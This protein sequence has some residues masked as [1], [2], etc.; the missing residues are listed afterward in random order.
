[1]KIVVVGAGGVG[2]YFGGRLAAHSG[3]DVTFLVRGETVGSGYPA[4]VPNS[5]KIHS[6]RF[7]ACSPRS[8]TMPPQHDSQHCVGNG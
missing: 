8:L 6:H 2:G 1:M 3:E 4:P 7:E 5:L